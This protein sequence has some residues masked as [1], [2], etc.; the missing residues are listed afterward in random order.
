MNTR[1]NRLFIR[2]IDERD[3]WGK[4]IG[5]ICEY[6]EDEKG[7]AALKYR[8]YTDNLFEK[9][10]KRNEPYCIIDYANIWEELDLITAAKIELLGPLEGTFDP[11]IDEA[12]IDTQSFTE[13]ERIFIKYQAEKVKRNAKV[14]N[15]KATKE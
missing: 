10:N 2:Y 4:F 13:L 15:L 14:K 8:D 1:L 3:Q 7:Y 9:L 6:V 5:H 11:I 12:H